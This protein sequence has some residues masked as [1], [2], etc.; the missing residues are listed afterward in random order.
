MVKPCARKLGFSRKFGNCWHGTMVLPYVQHSGGELDGFVDDWHEFFGLPE[1]D[2]PKAP[3]DRLLY[4]YE[5]NGEVLLDFRDSESGVGDIQLMAS[6][7]FDCRSPE[8]A[9]F[10]CRPQAAN[11]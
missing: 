8:S 6:K 4:Y 11:W 1:S 9:G 2:R 10:A 5:K 3:T 7:A